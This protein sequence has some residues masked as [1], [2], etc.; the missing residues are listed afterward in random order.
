MGDIIL[1]RE[2]QELYSLYDYKIFINNQQVNSIRNGSR[3]V[4]TLKPGKYDMYVKVLGAKSPNMQIEIESKKTLRLS[5]GSK[6]RGLKYAFSWFFLFSKNNIYLE[7][8]V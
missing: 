5:C 7:K 2:T 3:K 1:T 8:T 6:L 4:I